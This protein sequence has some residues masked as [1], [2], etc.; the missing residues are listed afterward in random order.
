VSFAS[1]PAFVAAADRE[2]GR[3]PIWINETGFAT[4]AGRS[5]R[6][7]ASWWARAVATFLA[8]PRVEHIGV[9]EIEDHPPDRPVIGDPPNYHLGLTRA[10]RT[11]KLAFHTVDI[12][13]DLLDVGRLAVEDGRAR[14]TVAAGA[15]G[16]LH[17]HLF[18]RPDDDRV[19]FVWDRVESPV[20]HVEL[21]VSG[22]AV[23]Y[24]LQGRAST[25]EAAATLG[26]VA[27]PPGVPRI[28]RVTPVRGR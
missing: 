12:L 10:D 19:L 26:R 24:D 18:R 11:P 16:E 7:Q 23:E 21:P 13:T 17:H 1:L 27:L 14:V 15:A 4:V 22:T 20:V 9:Y 2:R 25:A 8:T 3:K 6:E 28:F 5:E